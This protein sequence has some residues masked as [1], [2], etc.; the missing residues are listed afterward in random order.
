MAAPAEAPQ[1]PSE[2]AQWM[3]FLRDPT[4]QDDKAQPKARA[5]RKIKGVSALSERGSRRKSG[6]YS[7]LR[8]V[9]GRASGSGR[10]RGRKERVSLNH[11][12]YTCQ[13]QPERSNE[14][15][16]EDAEVSLGS[17]DNSG[18]HGGR[19]L[20]VGGRWRVARQKA[21]SPIGRLTTTS[22]QTTTLRY[23][24]PLCCCRSHRC[25]LTDLN[26]DQSLQPGL[27]GGQK[28]RRGPSE[29]SALRARRSFALPSF[30]PWWEGATNAVGLRSITT[31]FLNSTATR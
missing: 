3:A 31:K 21:R 4:N 10:D 29:P 27:T 18:R 7:A 26:A 28:N 19:N 11:N 20:G 12:S 25:L 24:S 22:V 5:G 15:A 2:G 14:Y 23:S 9:R 13:Q 1:R 8:R 6:T 16:R 17:K 30:P